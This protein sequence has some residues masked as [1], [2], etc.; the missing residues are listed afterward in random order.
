[1]HITCNC[2][3][4]QPCVQT[5]WPSFYPGL[6]ACKHD[7]CFSM[8]GNSCPVC[9]LQCTQGNQSF[10]DDSDLALGVKAA[11]QRGCQAL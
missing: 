9:W 11:G 8:Q 3:D 4:R 2:N 5:V 7:T 1:M 10:L 6:P